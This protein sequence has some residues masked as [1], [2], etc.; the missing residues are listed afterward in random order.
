MEAFALGTWSVQCSTVKKATSSGGQAIL[1]SG[2]ESS[3]SPSSSAAS[4]APE[5]EGKQD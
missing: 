4:S 5:R 1:G 3:A 2:V